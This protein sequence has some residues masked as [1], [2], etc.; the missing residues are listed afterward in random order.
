MPLFTQAISGVYYSSMQKHRNKR[1]KRIQLAFVYTLM[2][3]AVVAIVSILI[4]VVQG[5]RYNR[6]DG[7]IEQGG[8]VQFDSRPS[9]ATV[10]VDDVTLA[11]KTANKVTLTSGSH[12]ITMS[13]DGYSSW[14]KDVLVRAGSVLWL[15]YTLLFPNSPEI[16][17]A[18]RYTT[19]SSALASPNA[20]TM[21]VIVQA[22]APEIS[23]TTLDTDTP[24][25]SK[26]SIATE[27]FTAPAAGASQTFSLVSWDKDSNLLLVKHVYGDKTE[28]LSV[29]RRSSKTRNIT[30]ELG[31]S[32][33]KIAYSLG[34]SN[35]LYAR[36][37]SNELRRL[38]LG[39]ST[40]SGP[41]ATN[42]ANF[43][44]TEDRT[45]TYESLPDSE[46]IRTV[47]YV[48]SGNTKSRTIASFKE[49]TTADLRITTGEYYGEHYVVTLYGETLT[50]KKGNLPSSDSADALK[51]TEVAKLTVSGS[52][53]YLG[54]SPT[55]RMVYVG[56]GTRIV[57]Y[58]LELKNSATLSLQEPLVRDVAWLDGFHIAATGQN[59]YYYD[60]DGTNGQLFASNTLNQPAVL[61]SNE[62]YIYYFA[63]SEETTVLR[64][65]KLTND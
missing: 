44:V 19:V 30:T 13:R 18:S 48:T 60:F 49:S 27:N 32:V 43:T 24:V 65:V 59:S 28:Y 64:R 61:S 31:V 53:T 55:N 20:K 16:T 36:T 15:D 41:L 2:A 35:I 9:G 7:K 34:D 3:I 17:T 37:T 62:K 12:T 38:D 33:E 54:F 50:I 11:N 45:I 51:L 56:A 14:K 6:F 21:A 46:G 47:G 29:D 10:T 8:L 1:R 26:V 4:L 5:Y 52:G 40:V 23:L 57:T 63:M 58:D 42:V 39:S 25:T 22:Q